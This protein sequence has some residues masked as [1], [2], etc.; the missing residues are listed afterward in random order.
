MVVSDSML[1]NVGAEHADMI[2]ECFLGIKTEQLHI[3][4]EKR[5]LGSRENVTIHVGVNDLRTMRNL[6]FVREKY[7]R[8]W[9][10]QRG[11]S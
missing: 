3:V 6:D 2:V 4:L 5:D 11:N 10:Q 9:L 7:M 8:W 1:R